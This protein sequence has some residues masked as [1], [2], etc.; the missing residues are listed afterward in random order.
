MTTEPLMEQGAGL[1]PFFL[2]TQQPLE[3]QDVGGGGVALPKQYDV[4]VSS[5]SKIIPT[6]NFRTQVRKKKLMLGRGAPPVIK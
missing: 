4:S 6:N 1:H 2:K 5:G 3:P